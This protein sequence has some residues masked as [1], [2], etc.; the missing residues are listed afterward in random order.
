MNKEGTSLKK[1]FVEI[2]FSN[3]LSTLCGVKEC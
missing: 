3:S 2:V 1:R